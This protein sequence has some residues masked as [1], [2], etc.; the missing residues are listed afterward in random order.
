MK[1]FVLYIDGNEPIHLM[2]Q[3]IEFINCHASNGG[4][5]Y[6]ARNCYNC[7]IKNSKFIN[8][9]ADNDG[10]SLYFGNSITNFTINNTKFLRF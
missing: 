8:N 3:N 10:G 5:I 2:I 6:I 7:I 1:P 4:S 9:T